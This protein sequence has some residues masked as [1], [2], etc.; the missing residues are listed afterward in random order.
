[1]NLLEQTQ[2]GE[3]VGEHTPQSKLFIRSFG[4][5]AM[6]IDGDNPM[7]EVIPLEEVG[8][9]DGEVNTDRQTLAGSGTDADGNSF[10][11]EMEVSNTIVAAWLPLGTNRITVPHVRRGERVILWQYGDA[12][13]YYWT[14][15][16]LDD[17]VRRLETVVFRVSN[18]TDESDKQMNQDNSYWAEM[19]THKKNITIATSK[20]N[21]EE[22]KYTI[23]IDT[24]NHTFAV[25]DDIDNF[26]QIDSKERCITM[27]NADGTYIKMDKKI[28]DIHA[29][30]T[31]NLST[32]TFNVDVNTWNVNV[33]TATLKGNYNYKGGITSNGKNIS[34]SH[35]H[36][37]SGGPSPGGPVG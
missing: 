15:T 30:S 25:T 22:F 32:K 20:S 23:Q 9:I 12:D 13:Q 37:N 24:A 3:N 35:F 16:G 11:V 33:G 10:D 26:I 27:H 19:S 2:T 4:R 21:G 6:N 14:P 17:N 36:L 28:M 18:T 5:A 7:L 1:M 8:F 34:D 29:P 31:I